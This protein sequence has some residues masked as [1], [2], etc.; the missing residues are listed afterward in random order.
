[1]QFK[2]HVYFTEAENRCRNIQLEIKVVRKNNC[3]IYERKVSINLIEKVI[4]LIRTPFVHLE[5][6]KSSRA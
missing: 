2:I 4:L 5:A 1:M 3:E 6:R